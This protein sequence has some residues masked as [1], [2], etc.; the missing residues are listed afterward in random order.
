MGIIVVDVAQLNLVAIILA[1]LL[2]VAIIFR[3][4]IV[5]WEVKQQQKRAMKRRQKAFSE[6]QKKMLKGLQELA[7]FIDWVNKQFPNSKT[8]KQFWVQFQDAKHRQEWFETLFNRLAP[9][10]VIKP[11]KVEKKENKSADISQSI[12]K[13]KKETKTNEKENPKKAK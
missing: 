9:K 5:V 11:K 3:K 6:N 1:I 8:R 4:K 12:D 10:P 2:S 7:K 13:V